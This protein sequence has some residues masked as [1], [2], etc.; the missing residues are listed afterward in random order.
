MK[1]SEI[2]IDAFK[3]PIENAKALMIYLLLLI[4]GGMGLFIIGIGIGIGNITESPIIAAI[5]AIIGFIEFII[6]LLL[7]EGY[8]LDVV[9]IG[10]Y[11]E[12]KSPEIDF[13]RQILN[14]LKLLVLALIY[15]GISI[16]IIAILVNIH[17]YLI[18][19]GILIYVVAIFSFIMAQCK[20][21]KT[22]SLTEALNIDVAIKDISK[23][24]ILKVVA[25]VVIFSVISYA[26]TAVTNIIQQ[27]S[28]IVSLL[29]A[30]IFTIYLGFAQSRG[31]GLL[32]SH[33]EE[34][35][36]ETVENSKK[37]EKRHN[38]SP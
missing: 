11:R 16:I 33:I 1:I 31:Y 35:E 19:L 32:Y 18:I 27:Y 3:Y 9:K 30:M 38:G 5:I 34:N 29:L 20:L 28:T 8:V 12:N 4:A 25:I 10:I 24:G 22:D 15:V 36:G 37:D 6:M 23:I 17:P 21:A 7:M 2:L 14:G 13:S 26:L